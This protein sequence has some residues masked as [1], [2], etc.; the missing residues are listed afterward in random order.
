[1]PNPS[2]KILVNS[3]NVEFGYELISVIPYAYWLFKHNSLAG[4]ISGSGSEP[5]YYFSPNHEI[6]P[7]LRD[8]ANIRK[9]ETP[10]RHIHKARLDTSQFC[11]PPYK[12]FYANDKYHFDLVIYNRYNREWIQVP[13]LN[14]P[15]NFFSL[16][17]LQT[18]FENFSGNILYCNVDGRKE[19]HDRAGVLHLGDWDLIKKYPNV[20]SI[21][22]LEEDYN[23]AQLLAF[24]NC[25]KFLTTNGGGCILASY[26]GGVNIIYT[27][28][29]TV[30]G[31]VYARENVTG[32]F[33]YYPLF[34]GSKIV[35]VRSYP[36][37]L[38]QLL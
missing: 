34:G 14:R 37:I 2:N 15:I 10:N 9:L 29:Q 8:W 7:K 19:L 26:Y 16:D 4:T 33:E 24:S 30:N 11:P 6:D 13:E 28:P 25:P 38:K 5:L 22:D 21:H 27:N 18:I 12:E 36:D 20:T 35:N 23:L 1:M 3:Q 31:K 32:D 17:L